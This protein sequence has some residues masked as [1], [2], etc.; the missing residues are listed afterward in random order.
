MSN[1][2]RE[3]LC[4]G[5][6]LFWGRAV[7]ASLGIEAGIPVSNARNATVPAISSVRATPLLRRSHSTWTAE[8]KNPST[9]CVPETVTSTARGPRG[10]AHAVSVV[11][12]RSSSPTAHPMVDGE[13]A[14]SC[15]HRHLTC[16]ESWYA[17]KTCPELLS[18]SAYF[19][20]VTLR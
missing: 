2:W 1:V 7:R 13:L 8:P 20:G 15:R 4:G 19:A 14:G 12:S 17:R 10:P 5:A 16:C 6:L 18:S 3:R 9:P 11:R